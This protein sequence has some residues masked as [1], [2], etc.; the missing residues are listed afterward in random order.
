MRTK[1]DLSFW[2]LFNLSFGFFGVQIA[3]A[4]QTANISR[5]FQTLGADPKSLSF[6]WILPPLM[7]LIVQPFVGKWSDKTWCKLG[8]RV[9]YLIAGTAVSVLVMCLLP[10][11]GRLSSVFWVAMLIG[12]II[13]MLLDT[14]LNMAMQPFKMMVGDM[15][16][17]KQKTKA[18][19]IQSFL[20]NA[21]QVVGSVLPF[22]LTYFGVS[23]DATNGVPASLTYAFYVGAAVLILCVIYTCLNVKEMPPEEYKLY[24]GNI[25]PEDNSP[26]RSMAELLKTAPSAFWQVGLVQFFCWA[27]FLFMWNYSTGTIAETCWGATDSSTKEFQDAGD[28]VGVVFG[29]ESIAAVLWAIVIPYFKERKTAYIISIILGALGFFMIP[30][31]HNQYLLILPYALIG[32]TWSAMLAL[33][34]TI[35]TN[36]LEGDPNMGTYLGLFNGTICIP[37]IVASIAGFGFMYVFEQFGLTMKT[38]MLVSSIL[39]VLGAFFVLKIRESHGINQQPN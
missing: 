12:T 27:A 9:P 4:L 6:F 22:A 25:S 24:H 1:P 39:L 14:S 8:R 36:A 7:G 17:E 18:Y 20:V 29:V 37:Q 13:L 2:K 26:K 28:W 10:N 33:P 23:N 5:I 19:S 15:V 32:C 11:A 30:F 38:M 16:N 21:G 34:F 35:V 3:Y 31:I